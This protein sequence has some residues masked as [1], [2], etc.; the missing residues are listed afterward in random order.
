[1]TTPSPPLSA[2]V[3][4]L[5]RAADVARILRCSR[6]VIFSEAKSG[7]LPCVVIAQKLIRFEPAAVRG[8]IEARRKGA[9][10][11]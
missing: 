5:L 10:N 9:T 2:G 11:A 1:M 8:Y 4:E 3:D 6:S 7:R